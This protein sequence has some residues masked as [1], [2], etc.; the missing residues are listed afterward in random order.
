MKKFLFI[1]LIA[2]CTSIASYGKSKVADTQAKDSLEQAKNDEH[3]KEVV[4]SMDGYLRE[5]AS[6][7]AQ[8]KLA[9]QKDNNIPEIL[10]EAQNILIPIFGITIPFAMVC[11]VVYLIVNHETRRRKMKYDMVEKAIEHGQQIP[12]YVFYNQ[13]KEKQK[14]ST[15]NTCIV[16]LSV[17]FAITLFF[18]IEH[19][20]EVAALASMIFLI[21]L[22]R[23]IVYI[24]DR[25]KQEK[26]D[27][28]QNDTEETL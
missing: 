26:S 12:E 27:T 18:I 20:Y 23:L 2:L 11:I 10:S 19:D 28:T 22:G 8:K 4:K 13:S 21:G 6:E 7:E 17:G 15:L 9:T 1:A 25:K 5:I 3:V 16:L 24:L 14:N